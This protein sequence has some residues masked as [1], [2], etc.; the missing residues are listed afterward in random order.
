MADMAGRE[1]GEPSLTRHK[2][3]DRVSGCADLAKVGAKM[4]ASMGFGICSSSRFPKRAGY[5]K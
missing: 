2:T 4:V 5:G 3:G 1:A